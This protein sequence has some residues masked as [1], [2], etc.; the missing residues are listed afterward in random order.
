MTSNIQELLV[1]PLGSGS[2]TEYNVNIPPTVTTT[3]SGG[4]GYLVDTVGD[5]LPVFTLVL[6]G[7]G[8]IESAVLVLS[9]G[10][11]VLTEVTPSGIGRKVITGSSASIP[12]VEILTEFL[13]RKLISN[14]A[15][16]S[17]VE[18]EAEFTNGTIRQGGQLVSLLV[19]A[20]GAGGKLG[21]ASSVATVSVSP[22][23]QPKK[24]TGNGSSVGITTHE[25]VSAIPIHWGNAII[26]VPIEAIG[27]GEGIHPPLVG[28]Q[29][30]SCISQK[31]NLKSEILQW[32][33]FC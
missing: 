6:S 32:Q 22:Y 5:T 11:V 20:T 10:S 2:L 3:F 30:K 1:T 8:T 23:G 26:L 19:Q 25:F 17:L 33:S 15:F 24:L 4:S 18:I 7:D 12:E 29:L 28:M 14:G 13:G 21:S 31:I 9:G 27:E 16:N